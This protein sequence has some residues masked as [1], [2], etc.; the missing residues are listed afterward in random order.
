MFSLLK[1]IEILFSVREK[2]QVLSAILNAID[3][4]KFINLMF[5]DETI[6]CS[7]L[8]KI[9]KIYLNNAMDYA[10]EALLISKLPNYYNYVVS[11]LNKTDKIL[12]ICSAIIKII[13]FIDIDNT[14]P[15]HDDCEKIYNDYK[16]FHIN[17][18]TI[19]NISLNLLHVDK[20]DCLLDK[21]DCLL[22]NDFSDLFSLEV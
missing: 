8:I 9:I 18:H 13:S 14:L 7:E 5:V 15:N 10:S 6:C 20:P 22:E 19:I 21:P 3:A 4:H 16:I 12:G 2:D 1:T 11:L 17:F